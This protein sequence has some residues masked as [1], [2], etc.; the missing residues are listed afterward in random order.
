MAITGD[1]LQ[2]TDNARKVLERRYL[3]RD[4]E[5]RVTE[6]PADM[7]RRVA[8][9]IAQAEGRY[10]A[11][12]ES[13]RSTE[14]QFYDAMANLE[15]LPNSPTLMNAGREFQQLSA[16]FV[17]PI[18]DSME[19]IFDAVKNTALIHKSGGGTGFSFSRLR[20]ADDI[21]SS[22]KGVSSGPISFMSV[23][24]AATEAIKQGGTRR[25]ANM[26]VLRVDH[27]DI[28]DF[29][30]VKRD[31]QRL[32]NFNIS[33]GVTEEFMRAVREAQD[34][35]LINPRSGKPAGR[36]NAQEIF[37][38]IVRS[39]WE[40]GD[41]GLLFL[42]RIN[43]GNPT[44]QLGAIESTNPC[45][46]QPLLPYESCNLGSI[47]LSKMARGPLLQA[48]VDWDK[49]ARTVHLAVRFL[50]DVIDMNKLPLPQIA[51]MTRG[52][53]KIGLGVMGFADLLIMM[54]IPYDSQEA[55]GVAETVMGF[56]QNE[57][58]KASLQLAVERGEFPNWQ[59]SVYDT[60]EEPKQLR[61]ATTTTVAPTGTISIIA[62]TSSGIEPLFAI[63]FTR[64]VMEGTQL[65]ELNPLFEQVAREGG[66]YT[67]ELA[68]ELA[69]RGSLHDIQGVPEPIKRVFVTAHDVA[70][71]WHVRL[72]AAFQ[73]FTDNAVS[74]TVNF[75]NEATVE[76]VAWVYNLA[77]DLGCKGITIYRDGCRENQVLTTGKSYQAKEQ[78]PAAVEREPRERPLEVHGITRAMNTG[79]GKLYITVNEDEKGPFEVF[80]NMG[81]AGGCA[82][83]QTEAIARLVSLCF[84]T[85]IAVEHVI[86]QLKGIS[87]HLPSWEPGGG[88]ILSCADA[89]AQA[90]ERALLSGTAQLAIDF[91][92]SSFGHAGA[93]PECGGQLVAEEGCKKC[94]HCGYS[95]C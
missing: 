45:G 8:G 73:R 75:P 23:F 47:N 57:A 71:E 21:V 9:N 62:G 38:R 92:G 81:K 34:F 36:L 28:L 63:A 84:R 13:L 69:A 58:R 89:F 44:P 12:P 15:F 51:E 87:C 82:S 24:D 20:P 70:P 46:E 65:A 14:Q 94:H 88:R 95:Q 32:N 61:N 49:L 16:C 85:G 5:G 67:P 10:G 22:T 40:G 78:Q 19:S 56:I 25:G 48:E 91:N 7:F 18:E 27:P 60:P 3:K 39:A 29:I 72:Q 50:D 80:G 90:M 68:R 64:T 74:K 93:C 33:V 26:A 1:G 42:D 35:D 79:C 2:L 83:S 86:K 11:T 17:L 77:Y 76:E 31:Q 41:P 6:T 52:N 59:G 4:T 53:R 55:A 37:D 54:G 30:E 66:F 43:A